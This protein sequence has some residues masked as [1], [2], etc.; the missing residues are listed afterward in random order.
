MISEWEKDKRLNKKIELK[1]N[2]RKCSWKEM[3]WEQ[4][5]APGLNKMKNQGDTA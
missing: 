3:K 2:I 5:A 1:I 4:E